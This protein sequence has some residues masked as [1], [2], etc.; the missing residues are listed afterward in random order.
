MNRLGPSLGIAFALVAAC[1]SWS[2]IKQTITQYVALSGPVTLRIENTVGAVRVIAWNKPEVA[3]TAVKSANST[4]ALKNIRID[5]QHSG[6]MV[7]VTTRYAQPSD[8]GGVE[9]SISAPAGSS[10]NVNN[11][12]G[13]VNLAGF[14]GNV[15]VQTET[16]EVKATLS[17]VAGNR[18]IKLHVTT[19]AITLTVP[20]DTSATVHARST[21]G[22]FS[23][24]FSIAS[25]RANVVGAT[26][27]GKIGSGSG[28]IDL[29]T[30]TGA[31]ALRASP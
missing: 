30:T 28:R 21:V 25:T 6:S 15:D 10:L 24:D 23:S 11:T 7:S 26:A 31:I 18:S 9:Y 17:R 13:A 3:V 12:T 22:N 27:D 2:S 1:G 5:V 19:G 14:S 16:G 20:R 29:S 8:E 4:E